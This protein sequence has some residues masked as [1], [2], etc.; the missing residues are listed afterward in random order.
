[1][2]DFF[3]SEHVSFL[4]ALSKRMFVYRKEFASCFGFVLVSFSDVLFYFHDLP[5]RERTSTCCL[6]ALGGSIKS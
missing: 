4:Y 3:I 5:D 2:V 1:M 6:V